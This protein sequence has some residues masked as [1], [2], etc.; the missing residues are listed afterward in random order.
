MSLSTHVLDTG[1]G[2]PAAGLRVTVEARAGDGW[3]AV[4]LTGDEVL[5]PGLVDPGRLRHRH[6]LTPYAGRRLTGVV[7]GAWLRGHEVTGAAPQGAT[8]ARE[9]A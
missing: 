6:P 2:R 3:R 8:L 9:P 4:T 7:R 1:R 5:L